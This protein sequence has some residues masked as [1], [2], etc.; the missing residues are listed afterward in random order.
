MEHIESLGVNRAV[1]MVK[2]AT[3]VEGSGKG[4]LLQGGTYPRKGLG[5]CCTLWEEQSLGIPYLLVQPWDPGSA[6]GPVALAQLCAAGRGQY[7]PLPVPHPVLYC[8]F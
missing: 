8:T 2:R 7:Q 1:Q 3:G 5:C 6:L 4:R